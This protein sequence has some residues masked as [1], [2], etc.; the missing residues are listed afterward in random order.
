MVGVTD[1]EPDAPMAVDIE[2]DELA[3]YPFLYWPLTPNQP[4]P[5]TAAYAK[6]NR[7]L[8]MQAVVDVARRVIGKP[9][10]AAAEAVNCHHNYVSREHHYG[11]NLLVTRKGAVRAARVAMKAAMVA[12]KVAMTTVATAPVVL[13]AMARP[14]NVPNKA[15]LM[16]TKQH[17]TAR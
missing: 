15:R 17:Q 11:E 13:S 2:R 4:M 14:R 8:M 6:L 9:F 5:S 1:D 16:P 7:A 12:V 10:E 3:F